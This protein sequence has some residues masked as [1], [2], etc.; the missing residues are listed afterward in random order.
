M[1]DG[2]IPK[3]GLVR[4]LRLLCLIHCHMIYL[5][6]ICLQNFEEFQAVRMLADGDSRSK[7]TG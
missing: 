3:F 2:L 4:V 6:A 7:I 5:K 1:A